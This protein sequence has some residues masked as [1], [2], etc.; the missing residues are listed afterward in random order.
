MAKRRPRRV[1]GSVAVLTVAGALGV[2]GC[3]VG[4]AKG[5]E[6]AATHPGLGIFVSPTVGAGN[7]SG[8]P[9]VTTPYQAPSVSAPA[10]PPPGAQATV[11]AVEAAVR[12][13]CWEDSHQANVYGA[14]DQLFWWQGDCGDTVAMVDLELYP[15]AAAAS[16]AAHHGTDTALL[17]RYLDGAVLVDVY[18]NAPQ[19][20]LVQ[21]GTVRGLRPVPGYGL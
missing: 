5:G 17:E 15:S 1:F 19:A 4:V 14:Y 8:F 18:G 16:S 2:A 21:L 10:T 6:N 12:G 20:V 11:A 9:G 13:G 7:I 3:G